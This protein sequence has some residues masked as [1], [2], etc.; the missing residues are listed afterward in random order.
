[1]P[2]PGRFGC[3]G[4]G[5]WVTRGRARPCARRSTC[6]NR[7]RV[8][9]HTHISAG[10]NPAPTGVFVVTGLQLSCLSN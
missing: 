2:R 7:Q 5:P 10:H 1:M 8:I 3:V 9:V 4:D 6:T